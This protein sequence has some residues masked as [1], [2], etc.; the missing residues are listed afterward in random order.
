M[1]R[2][3]LT[4][5]YDGIN[6]FGSQRQANERTVQ[7]EL[8]KALTKI[9]WT[10]SSVLIAGRTDT[11][12]HATGQV[13]S[14]DLN[15]S[16]TDDAL[17]HA[18]NSSLPDDM[19]VKSAQVVADKFHPRFDA[20]SRLYRY[21]LFFQPH[22]DPIRERYAWRVWPQVSGDDLENASKQLTG[23]HDFSA[24]GS[25]TTP[26]GTTVRTV[27]KAD[28]TQ[29]TEDEWHFEV[30]ANAF[31]YRMV[32]RMVFIQVTVAQGKISADAIAHSLAN[33]ESA[34]SGNGL[35]SGLAPAHGL[36]LINVEYKT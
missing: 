36:T 11:G 31:L 9:G 27:I 4:L 5:A 21:K 1:V 8:E 26:K 10:G 14:V 12:V 28:W 35:L 17:I 20:L 3:K 7:G 13:V 29:A 34:E 2:Y 15:W 23:M 24:F 32:R 33:Q 25:P 6:F 19:S 18:L 22:R 30:Q 16:H